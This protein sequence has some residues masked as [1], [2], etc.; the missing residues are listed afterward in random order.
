MAS[1][2]FG[3]QFRGFIADPGSVFTD[4]EIDLIG[5]LANERYPGASDW[6]ILSYAIILGI[7]MIRADASKRTSYSQ[8][9]ASESTSA[10]ARNLA[11]LEKDWKIT[12]EEAL[13]ANSAGGVR[14]GGHR[15]FPTRQREFPDA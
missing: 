7:R 14:W 4:P 11:D 10:I 2:L 5:D 1:E 6:V 8:N 13:T 3:Q 9:S 12:L 15:T